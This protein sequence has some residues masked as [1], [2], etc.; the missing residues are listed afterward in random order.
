M[1]YNSLDPICDIAINKHREKS[2]EY[3]HLNLGVLKYQVGN[4]KVP[5]R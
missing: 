5:V 1:E 2:F 4:I 3:D